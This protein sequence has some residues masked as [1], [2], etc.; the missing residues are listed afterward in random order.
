MGLY[1][2]CTVA[3]P[4]I[5]QYAQRSTELAAVTYLR[6]D[7]TLFC[8]LRVILS[9]SYQLLWLHPEPKVLFHSSY[10]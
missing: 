1:I 8:V 5:L 9:L 4:V 7:E 6:A 2:S 10:S 3:Q